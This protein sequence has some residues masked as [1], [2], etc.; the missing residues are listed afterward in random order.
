MSIDST[1]DIKTI[2][3]GGVDIKI[4]N[5]ALLNYFSKFGTIYSV[6]VKKFTIKYYR[7]NM[8]LTEGKWIVNLS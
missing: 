5:D 2:F 7:P 8:Y 4:S 1:N 3:V 6:N